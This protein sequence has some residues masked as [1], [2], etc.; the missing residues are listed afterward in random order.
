MKEEDF[1]IETERLRLCLISRDYQ[2]DIF[3][4]FTE[5][6]AQFLV[7]K[8]TGKIEDTSRFIEESRA[9]SLAGHNCQLVALE[10]KTGKF[11]GCL[12]VHHLDEAPALGIWIKES[13]WGQGYGRE[14]IAALKVWAKKNLSVA[15]VSYPVFSSNLRSRRLAEASGGI[16]KRTM[17]GHDSRDQETDEIEYLITL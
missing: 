7:N 11:I 15:Q 6:V 3:R 2:D 17:A 1:S 10:R 5:T 14:A 16:F 13:A 4:E 9:A 8:P 12:G